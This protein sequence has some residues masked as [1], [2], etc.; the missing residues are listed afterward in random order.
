MV[1]MVGG[2]FKDCCGVTKQSKLVVEPSK[3]KV[4]VSHPTKKASKWG[5]I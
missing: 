1:S 4:A 5:N 3:Q 2:A